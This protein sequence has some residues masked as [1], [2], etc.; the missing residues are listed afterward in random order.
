MTATAPSPAFLESAAVQR[1]AASLDDLTAKERDARLAVVEEFSAFV[2]RP[3]DQMAEEI[4]DRE[5]RKYKKRGFYT[6]MVKEFSEQIEGPWN[7]QTARGN[8]VRSFFIANGTRL[9]PEKPPWMT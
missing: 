6:E 1:Y 5:T 2:G 3:P 4:F 8:I 7:Q 9:V